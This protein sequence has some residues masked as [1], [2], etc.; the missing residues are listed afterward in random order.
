MQDNDTHSYRTADGKYVDYSGNHHFVF[1][2]I[3]TELNLQVDKAYIRVPRKA[4]YRLPKRLQHK[5]N[6]WIPAFMAYNCGASKFQLYPG[7]N[8]L[9]ADWPGLKFE[10]QEK[11]HIPKHKRNIE[12]KHPCTTAA[13]K[14]IDQRIKE[15]QQNENK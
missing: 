8:I 4:Q 6:C 5:K 15:L 1:A 12:H 7:T 13:N 3:M 14:W 11:P 9:I 10:Q 2:R